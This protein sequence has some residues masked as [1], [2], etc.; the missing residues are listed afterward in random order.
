MLPLQA[1]KEALSW[2]EPTGTILY[3]QVVCTGTYL[4]ILF[5]TSMYWYILVFTSF[6][7][8]NSCV[9]GL[10]CVQDTI[11]VVPP[12]PYCIAEDI[13]DVPFGDCWYALPQLFFK[14]HL[15]PTG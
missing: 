15:S 13:A 2:H 6:T 10:G 5:C 1:S 7:F 8:F 14:C 4:Y 9:Q 11:V 12:S 3:I